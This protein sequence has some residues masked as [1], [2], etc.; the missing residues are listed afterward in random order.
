MP[1]TCFPVEVGTDEFAL[2]ELT[3]ALI[4]GG[5]FL[6]S[7]AIGVSG[8]HVLIGSFFVKRFTGLTVGLFSR[9][10]ESTS[11]FTE[12]QVKSVARQPVRNRQISWSCI[13][14]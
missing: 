2:T 11:T 7:P 9:P 5:C 12:R 13:P 6:I 1:G 3:D 8:L 14:A 10:R 4:T